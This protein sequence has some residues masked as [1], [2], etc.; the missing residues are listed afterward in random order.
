VC[1]CV[2]VFVCVVCTYVCTYVC[3]YKSDARVTWGSE[4]DELNNNKS[5]R[6]R[7]STSNEDSSLELKNRIFLARYYFALARSYYCLARS[8]YCLACSYYCLARSCYCFARSRFLGPLIFP[9]Y[10]SRLS[11][12]TEKVRPWVESEGDDLLSKSSEVLLQS[13]SSHPLSIRNS[14]KCKHLIK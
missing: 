5:K 13:V 6:D 8:Y 4:K 2:C 1:V 11:S 10:L 7:D 12:V 3:I 9:S 14:R